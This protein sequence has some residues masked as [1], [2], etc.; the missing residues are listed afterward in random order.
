MTIEAP[1]PP[2]ALEAP[3]L[4]PL[5]SENSLP[6]TENDTPA[7]APRPAVLVRPRRSTRRRG[8]RPN[9]QARRTEKPVLTPRISAYLRDDG[10]IDFDR[11]TEATIAQLA[12]AMQTPEARERLGLAAPSTSPRGSGWESTVPQ[13]VD[14][15]NALTLKFAIVPKFE[16]TDEEAALFV[17]RRNPQA[18]G[19][20]CASTTFLL[21]K[22]FPGGFG[23]YDAA[24]KGAIALVG[25]VGESVQQ[26]QQLR[27]TRMRPRPVTPFDG[28]EARVD[29]VDD[30]FAAES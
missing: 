2:E 10:S 19:D 13:L 4:P 3:A 15:V 29:A 11:T 21:D 5:G 25:F 7:P 18:H 1:D 6:P 17:L 8:R 22:F 16:L 26:L 24:I 27:R 28:G 14:V 30:G 9:P 20:V 12:T 23:E